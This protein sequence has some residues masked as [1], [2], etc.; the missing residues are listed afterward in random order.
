M[1][2]QFKPFDELT[3]SGR[4]FLSGSGQELVDDT[5]KRM[6]AEWA[7]LVFIEQ[8]AGKIEDGQGLLLDWTRQ[9][10]IA[11]FCDHM[12]ILRTGDLQLTNCKGEVAEQTRN[13]S[14]TEMEQLYA[15]MD[16]YT[17]FEFVL[18]DTASADG[19]REEISFLGSGNHVATKLEQQSVLDFVR[20]L[21]MVSQP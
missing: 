18:Q 13:L 19:M 7:A 11:G 10:G 2:D 21:F 8:E 3:Q 16:S 17:S 4:I 1:V 6:I 12:Q 14:S 9:G 20:T 5:R 15:W